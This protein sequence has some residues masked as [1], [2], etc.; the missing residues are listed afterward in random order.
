MLGLPSTDEALDLAAVGL[1]MAGAS[2]VDKKFVNPF[3]TK[4]LP[5][6]G[7]IGEFVDAATTW[8][9]AE[10]L[11]WGVGLVAPDFRAP[12][13]LGGKALAVGKVISIPVPGYHLDATLPI[14]LNGSLALPMAGSGSSTAVATTGSGSTAASVAQTGGV[15]TNYPAPNPQFNVGF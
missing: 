2:F 14:A 5:A 6:S 12:I 13:A 7:P 11:G 8:L 9:S 1:G 15:A 3:A 10:A 4:F